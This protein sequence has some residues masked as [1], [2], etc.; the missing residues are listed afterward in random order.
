M[1]VIIVPNG[2]A[3]SQVSKFKL[4]YAICSFVFAIAGESRCLFLL[5]AD[6][7]PTD[8]IL[9]FF[10]G[11]VRTPQKYGWLANAA[12]WINVFIIIMTMA[13]VPG[14]GPNYHAVQASAGIALGGDLVTADAN[15]NFPPIVHFVRL[16]PDSRGFTGAVNGLM[17]AVYASGVAMLF[18]EFMSEMKRPR[19]FWKGMICAQG[20]TY[21]AYMIYGCFLFNWMLRRL[22]RSADINQWHASTWRR[23]GDDCRGLHCGL[24]NQQLYS[25]RCRVW[26]RML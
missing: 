24:Q 10:I 23:R 6:G 21:L 4:C 19:D 25:R 12:I 8:I 11:Q 9:G 13:V 16:P 18:T 20:F 14:E 2:Q 3:L 1:G 15:G 7:T 17:Q 5:L 26:R 22:C